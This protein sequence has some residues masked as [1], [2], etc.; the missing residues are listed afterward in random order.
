[1]NNVAPTVTANNAT[2]TVNEGQT[3]ANTGA[4]GDVGV[5]SVT[6]TASVGTITQGS[7]T[8]SWSFVTTDG[9]DQSGNVTITAT[10]SDGA[11]TT[12][13]FALVVNN[14]T[15]TVSNQI[16]N[17]NEDTPTPITLTGSDVPADPLTWTITQAPL[18]GSLSGS[19]PNLTYTPTLNYY[20]PDSF[21][22]TAS[23][24]LATSVEATVTITISPV[25]DNPVANPDLAFTS[26]GVPAVVN[27]LSNDTD[28]ENDTLTITSVQSPTPN[29]GTVTFL[30]PNI[31][32]VAM[33]GFTGPDTFTYTISDGNGGTATGSVTVFVGA[34]PPSI[35]VQPVSQTVP[36]ATN[37]T[38]TV[39]A[40]GSAPLTYQWY[41]NGVLIP[42]ATNTTY[43]IT[44][45]NLADQ[46][47]YTVVVTNF[48]GT[49]TSDPATLTVTTPPPTSPIVSNQTAPPGVPGGSFHSLRPGPKINAL[50]HAMFRAWLVVDVGGVTTLDD[51]GIWYH[52]NAGVLQLLAREGDLAHGV[53]GDSYGAFAYNPS[54]T[55]GEA[56]AYA[57]TLLLNHSGIWSGTSGNTPALVLKGNDPAPGVPG[58]EIAN[59]SSYVH[60]NEARVVAS[61][62][63]LKTGIAGVTTASDGAILYGPATAPGSLQF[64]A[65]EGSSAADTDGKFA[66]LF[67]PD[68]LSLDEGGSVLYAAT[69]ASQTTPS[70]IGANNNTGIWLYNGLSG[71]SSLVARGGQNATVGAAAGLLY[72]QPRW[73]VLSGGKVA[74]RSTLRGTVIAGVDDVALFAGQPGSLVSPVTGIARIG[75]AAPA[76]GAPVGVPAGAQFATLS[77][78]RIGKGPGHEVAFFGTLKTLIAGVTGT[79]SQGIWKQNAGGALS[80]IARSGNAIP[81]LPGA[82]FG[83][84][85]EP[86]VGENGQVFFTARIVGGG[87]TTTS[88]T[89]LFAE[90]SDG[91]LALM[92][93]EGQS[94]STGLGTRTIADMLNTYAFPEDARTMNLDGITA[95]QAPFTD[96]SNG[97]L[98]ITVP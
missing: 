83:S 10:D 40:S 6:L 36:A 11:V 47:S 85:G 94:V 73:G 76:V 52:N 23:D 51:T 45:A 32:H 84:L 53:P 33:I 9:P 68:W 13:T 27:V 82:I 63:L 65:R 20:G 78:P 74:F 39:T 64:I 98:I 90:R 56:Y 19:A 62:A 16:L 48:L 88:D 35:T 77:Y 92:A 25:N 14:L 22:Y 2:V 67:G 28:V 93:R 38:F 17:L 81:G 97:L 59:L 29:G 18:H 43:T 41:K 57:S 54:W 61:K 75:I 87:A 58:A 66:G 42:G 96:G 12:T 55:D 89:G 86:A 46:A 95:I 91:S 34:D 7:G 30:G 15:P 3:A 24:G 1:V 5:D 44:T 31:T 69:L 72:Y 49:A 79:N 60:M 71:T 80:L 50:R 21:K 37:A 4:F 70:V 26:T 8:W